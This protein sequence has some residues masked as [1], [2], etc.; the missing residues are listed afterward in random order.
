MW[1]KPGQTLTVNVGA[2]GAG[3]NGVLTSGFTASPGSAGGTTSILGA[4]SQ[5]FYAHAGGGGTGGRA[6]GGG[7]GGYGGLFEATGTTGGITSGVPM[8]WISKSQALTIAYASTLQ[9]SFEG[10]FGCYTISMWGG[11]GGTSP[12]DCAPGLSPGQ[13]SQGGAYY[14]SG[15]PALQTYA[16]WNGGR[17]GAGNGGSGSN[18]VSTIAAGSRAGAGGAGGN[19]NST[20]TINGGKGADGLVILSW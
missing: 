3:G 7:Y 11:A 12:S 18:G 15:N 2:G 10:G 13:S 1:V 9:R 14:E 16:M 6:D 19:T 5:N 8:P 20:G 17:G 4:Q